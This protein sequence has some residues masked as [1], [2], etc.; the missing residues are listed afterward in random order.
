M[1]IT[2]VKRND[3]AHTLSLTCK[4][5]AG[6]AGSAICGGASLVACTVGQIV[7]AAH[8]AGDLLYPPII[9]LHEGDTQIK[10]VCTADSYGE[11]A[12]CFF[13]AHTAYMLLAFNHPDKVSANITEDI[14]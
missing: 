1:L 3:E 8:H 13:F 4:G 14:A 6:E 10:C 9:E 11:L 7:A 5:H 2:E 12:R